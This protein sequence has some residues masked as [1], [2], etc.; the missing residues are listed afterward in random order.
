MAMTP[1]TRLA[2]VALISPDID[3]LAGFYVDAFGFAPEPG[4]LGGPRPDRRITL[5][6]GAQ[7][8]D[9]L[10]FAEP[11]ALYPADVSGWN[12]AFQHIAII[13]TDMSALD[14]LARTSGWRAISTDGPQI[15]PAS[16][17]GVTAFKFRDPDGHPLEFLAFPPGAAPPVWR[18]SGADGRCLGYDH[19]AISVR[20]TAASVAFYGWLGLSVTARS[21]NQGPE[22]ARLDGIE[23]PTVEV[24]TLTPDGA[25]TPHVELL[26]YRGAY[27]R[28]A[29]DMGRRDV[30][31]SRLILE[32][33]AARWPRD[34]LLEERSGY[35]L[36]RD[37]D[38]HLLEVRRPGG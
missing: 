19:S 21:L 32:V 25:P 27:D 15:L 1:S 23:A 34:G 11:G 30:A 16:S 38:G 13:V 31:A 33:D 36:L 6:L 12:L 2:G 20:D 29:S 5:R 35:A 37:P 8:L 10:E 14:R 7:T 18:S 26:C 4:D 22:Q 24:T 9:L 28:P 17:G 3:R